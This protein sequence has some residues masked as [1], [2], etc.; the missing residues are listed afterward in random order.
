MLSEKKFSYDGYKIPVRLVDLTGG[1]TDD[2]KQI[3]DYHTEMYRKYTPVSPTDTIVEIGCGVGR[4]AISL[5]KVL[6][7]EGRYIG[8][9]IIRDSI[10]W[11]Q[12]NITKRHKNFVFHY[13]DI[14]SQIHNSGGKIKTTDT[15]IPAEDGSVDRIF[16]H[17]VF[18]HMFEKDIVHYLREFSRV[19]KPDGLVL[20]SFF[21]ADKLSMETVRSTDGGEKHRHPLSF[22]YKYSPGCLINDRDY[23]EGAVAFTPSK[24]KSMLLKSGMR[25]HGNHVHRGGWSGI[26]EA[27]NGQD[28]LILEKANMRQVAAQ[29]SGPLTFTSR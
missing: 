24:L 12:K 27:S 3:S 15:R 18:T 22:K 1:G 28:I 25:I 20:A 8:T 14:E 23:P 16:L 19:L 10:V 6:G 21:V 7:P 4:D 29:V 17:S 26:K 9:D 13:F 11:A 2:W 5:S